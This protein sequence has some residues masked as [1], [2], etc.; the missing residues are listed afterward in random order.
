M[1]RAK[2]ERETAV[3]SGQVKIATDRAVLVKL[4]SDGREIWIPRSQIDEGDSA[5]E[6]DTDLSVS[7]W[8]IEK[9]GIA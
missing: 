2:H 9:E 4:N 8:F 7:T 3:I 1:P 6:G 5:D